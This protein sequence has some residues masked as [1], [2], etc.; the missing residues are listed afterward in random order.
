VTKF[1]PLSATKTALAIDAIVDRYDPE[2]VR[3]A[4][5]SARGRDV[6]APPS[7]HCAILAI[8]HQSPGTAPE[9]SCNGSS[10]A[11]I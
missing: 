8:A 2:A 1:G 6:V 9:P 11:G 7:C 3:R 5:A 4:R 10:G